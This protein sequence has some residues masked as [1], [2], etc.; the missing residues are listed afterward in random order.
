MEQN[1]AS[2]ENK[3]EIVKDGDNDFYIMH[4]GRA[5]ALKTKN[6]SGNLI[7]MNQE[8]FAVRG[9]FEEGNFEDL[10]F[11]EEQD[12]SSTETKKTK[13]TMYI[14]EINVET[15]KEISETQSI[16]AQLSTSGGLAIISKSELLE[17]IQAVKKRQAE[18]EARKK[19]EEEERKR[20]KEEERKRKEEEE[21]KRKE[22][23][24]ETVFF[25][26]EN[27]S[28]KEKKMCLK[29]LVG[30]SKTEYFVLSKNG[31]RMGLFAESGCKVKVNSFP[32]D[33]PLYLVPVS[34][35][36]KG[37]GKENIKGKNVIELEPTNGIVNFD[38]I[39]KGLEEKKKNGKAKEITEEASKLVQQK[40]E[41]KKREE[42]KKKRERRDKIKSRKEEVRPSGFFTES[43]N[44]I[45]RYR[46]KFTDGTDEYYVLTEC[47]DFDYQ[48]GGIIK[49]EAE[50]LA[51]V[52]TNTF[53]YL[54]P[55]DVISRTFPDG[56]I[57]EHLSREDIGK[58]NKS[59][60]IIKFESDKKGQNY[61]FTT[62]ESK[63]CIETIDDKKKE[64]KE[65]TTIKPIR[66]FTDPN[67][68]KLDENGT[69]GYRLKFT[70]G[71]DEYYVF[72]RRRKDFYFHDKELEAGIFETP[73][74]T[75]LYLIPSDI[76][77]RTFPDGNIPEHL[78]YEDANKIENSKGNIELRYNH[79]FGWRK[80]IRAIKAQKE[81]QKEK[82]E[83]VQFENEEVQLT[84]N[85]L[86][87]ENIEKK[88]RQEE[89][90]VPT[91]Q[92][93]MQED[94]E[95]KKRK[96]MFFNMVNNS[97]L[98]EDAE[99]KKRQ[100]EQ[101]KKEEEARR[102]QEEEEKKEK[103]KR[104]KI[105]PQ[106]LLKS[107]FCIEL[108]G[109]EY[110]L[111]IKEDG[112]E[113]RRMNQRDIKGDRMY[114]E[115]AFPESGLTL[116][117]EGEKTIFISEKTKDEKSGF[118]GRILASGNITNISGEQLVE[119]IQEIQENIKR[120]GK[121]GV[122]MLK[123]SESTIGKTRSGSLNLLSAFSDVNK[124]GEE[125]D[126]GSIIPSITQQKKKNKGR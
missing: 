86:I 100:E 36:Q 61:V 65:K 30:E 108:D 10:F 1:E 75:T 6:N 50:E 41:E 15:K 110:I 29:T 44:I 55:S 57:P 121:D 125:I 52:D 113:L 98:R 58:I 91:I 16:S 28:D 84:E 122:G 20:K 123:N 106:G 124:G 40:E 43:T 12:L 126:N 23:K 49:E 97:Y 66:F 74:D 24:L 64:L 48:R 83:T 56:D 88:K 68:V 103:L 115:T 118:S 116:A 3:L 104:L 63:K 19:A 18:E 105:V 101:R 27:T 72:D 90:Q 2:A 99:N 9:V 45:D 53:C 7:R 119:K 76:I 93:L 62:F 38:S 37:V 60:N 95:G 17:G 77:S 92:Q 69:N 111:R 80:T 89:E 31:L 82:E 102:K 5:Y 11:L 22:G 51:V 107:E 32:Y 33:E 79:I 35:F 47:G 117:T 13:K 14:V 46:L 59:D 39:E 4:N 21:R 120:M 96:D 26:D 81:R 67:V 85:T 73:R 70:D 42:E 71:T 54:V 94:S 78:S 25:S 109:K 8:H 87:G 114:S 34:E 112:K